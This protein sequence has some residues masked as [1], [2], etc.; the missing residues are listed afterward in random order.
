MVYSTPDK[1]AAFLGLTLSL[2]QDDLVTDDLEPAVRAYIDQFTGRSW[3]V[4]S[5][6]TAEQHTVS[7]GG[8]Y[9]KH[10]PV[11]AISAASYRSPYIGASDTALVADS[12]YELLDGA[13]GK[14]LVSAPDGS[15]LSVSYTHTGTAVPA[16]I[17]HAATLLV[18][19][20]LHDATLAD[21]QF[22][23]V[24]SYRVGNGDLQLDFDTQQAATYATD[25]LASLKMRRPA[26]VFA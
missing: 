15:I 16:D 24:K 25:A 21:P 1:V 9:L 6:V 20:Q 11:S 10:R 14:L 26:V 12:T 7:G 4:S 5:P 8:V 23:G 3:E 18:A 19:A 17:A 13:T 2:G 22:R